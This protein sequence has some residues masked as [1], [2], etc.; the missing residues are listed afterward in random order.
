MRASKWVGTMFR[1]LIALG[2]MLV[3]AGGATAVAIAAEGPSEVLAQNGFGEHENSYAW[4]M[5][6]FHGKLYVGTGRDVLCVEDETTQFFVPIEQKYTIDPELNVR[7]PANP[8]DLNLRAEIWQ[9]TPHAHKWAIVYHAPTEQNPFDPK[10]KV[11]TDIAYRS[12]VDYKAPG[13]KEAIYA[14]GVT[15]DEY[16]PSLLTSHPP[17]IMRSYDGVHWQAL[18]LPRVVVHYPGGDQRPMGFRQ[19]L[20]W[21]H[22]LYVTAT[23]DLTGNGSLFEIT[24]PLS[25]DP[26]LVQVSPPDLNVF[27]VATL[28]GRSVP[29]V[30]QR[31][32]RLLGVGGQRR[33][34]PVR[35]DRHGRSGS[36]RRHHLGGLDA[37][38]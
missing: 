34:P 15:A 1:T 35:P 12:M 19:L 3:I 20:V 38:V 10:V 33:G 2:V 36:R 21:R 26:G 31:A 6:W 27:E 25:N 4:S 23:P 9:Y 16:L 37:R 28:G 18:H 14:A 11:A 8:Y 29:R 5:G 30:R 32:V 24:R 7:C 13:A 17:R 22:H